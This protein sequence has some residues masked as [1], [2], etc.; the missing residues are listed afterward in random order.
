MHPLNAL[1]PIVFTL[2]G[3]AMEVKF[4]HPLNALAPI[5]AT[6]LLEISIDSK[7]VQP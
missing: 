1:A 6:L 4:V 3:I 7:S 5:F 2:F